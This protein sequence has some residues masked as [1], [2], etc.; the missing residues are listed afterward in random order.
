M[1]YKHYCD[2]CGKESTKEDFTALEFVA[3]FTKGVLDD[4]F[5]GKTIMRMQICKPCQKEMLMA[6]NTVLSH[7]GSDKWRVQP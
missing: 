3:K 7:S 4:G 2:C 6:V 5:V 1:G